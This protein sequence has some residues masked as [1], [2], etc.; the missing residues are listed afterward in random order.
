[1]ETLLVKKL[2]IEGFS[3]V[4]VES[5]VEELEHILFLVPAHEQVHMCTLALRSF[6]LGEHLSAGE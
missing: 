2:V 6:E 1:M 5:L 3:L 4:F